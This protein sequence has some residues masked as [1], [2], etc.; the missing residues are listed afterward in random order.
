MENDTAVGKSGR[1]ETPGMMCDSSCSWQHLVP[2]VWVI[3]CSN[4]ATPLPLIFAFFF[5]LV[6]APN[7]FNATLPPQECS[8]AQEIHSY[9]CHEFK[10]KRNGRMGTRGKP[11]WR[12]SLTKA[13][14]L[15]LGLVSWCYLWLAA[16]LCA[17][18]VKGTRIGPL[19][20]GGL[21]DTSFNLFQLQSGSSWCLSIA[22]GWDLAGCAGPCDITTALSPPGAQN[23][24]PWKLGRH[25]S[26]FWTQHWIP[27]SFL[28]PF[29]S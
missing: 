24:L 26:L 23:T 2:L 28:A 7:C 1:Q 25:L 5:F 29:T 15:P 17:S 19:V 12:N 4:Q 18:A 21:S 9:F 22:L 13:F 8:T 20:W 14:S 3:W 6:E 11:C 16:W 10:H 27:A